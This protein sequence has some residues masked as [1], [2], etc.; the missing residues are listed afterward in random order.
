VFEARPV[1][2]NAWMRLGYHALTV[3]FVFLVA[4]YTWAAMSHA[5]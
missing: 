2:T 5:C 1:L 4:T 3:A